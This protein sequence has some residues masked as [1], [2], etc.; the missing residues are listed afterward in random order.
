MNTNQS[1][2]IGLM[3][4]LTLVQ[5]IS[6]QDKEKPKAAQPSTKGNLIGDEYLHIHSV[7][8]HEA[9]QLAKLFREV[10]DAQRSGSSSWG[11]IVLP[12][13]PVPKRN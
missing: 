12:C 8:S 11:M 13:G 10:F 2:L 4:T 1:W 5:G 3:A 9:V 7:P 6:A